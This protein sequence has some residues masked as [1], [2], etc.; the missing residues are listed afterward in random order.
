MNGATATTICPHPFRL[1]LNLMFPE[2]R[3]FIA[4]MIV[5]LAYE[6]LFSSIK[7]FIYRASLKS[8]MLNAALLLLVMMM[9][10]V[11]F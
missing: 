10:L 7:I 1:L 9:L 4:Y 11:C 8:W 2:I 5:H 6:M 3:C